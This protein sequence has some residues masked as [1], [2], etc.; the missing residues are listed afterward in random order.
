[1][2]YFFTRKLMFVKECDAVVCLPGGFGTLDEALEVLT[3]LQTG[4]RDLVPVVL[5]DAPGG[6]YWEKLHDF[7][8][9]QLLGE[10]MICEEDLCLYKV[11]DSHED[12]ME[13][14]LGFYRVY[15]SMRYVK[16][17]LVLRLKH[18]LDESHVE[19]I[20]GLFRDVLV[21][22]RFE[23]REAFSDE[24]DEPDLAELP[25]LAF[26]FNRRNLGR[27]RQ[28]IDWINLHGPAVGE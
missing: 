21:D 18:A 11:T 22:G 6:T 14:V 13:E 24:R 23:Q 9:D 20:N 3:L 7:I 27:L 4:K 25:R 1:M 28:L 15:H 26:H 16:H 10:G 12:A 8:A 5:L 2:K 17:H 19:A